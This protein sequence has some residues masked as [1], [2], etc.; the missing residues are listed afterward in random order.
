VDPYLT[1][2]E[3]EPIHL[4]RVFAICY[5]NGSIVPHGQLVQSCMVENALCLVGQTL[6]LLGTPDPRLT[7]LGA[8]D[9]RLAQLLRGFRAT[10]P[11]PNRVHPIPL[12]ILC[13]AMDMAATSSTPGALATADMACIAFFFLL[14]PGE[15]TAKPHSTAPFTLGDIQLLHNDQ[16]LSWQELPEP[17]LLMAN[18]V[19]YTFLSVPPFAGSCTTANTTHR[20]TFH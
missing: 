1:N 15:Y 10:D 14:R 19:T 20:L 13:T 17:A 3:F 4:L 5:R 18:Y 7:A 9:F 6:A 16:I 12:K 11:A 8:T 2:I